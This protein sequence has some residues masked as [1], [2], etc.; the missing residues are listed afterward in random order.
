MNIQLRLAVVTAE[1][2]LD[3]SAF[4]GRHVLRRKGL[5]TIP[6]FREPVI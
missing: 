6:I 2:N 3:A 5:G 1:V 4:W